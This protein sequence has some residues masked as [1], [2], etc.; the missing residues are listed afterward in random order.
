M[1]IKGWDYTV[2]PCRTGFAPVFYIVPDDDWVYYTNINGPLH[3]PVRID[4]TGL[5][6]GFHWIRVDEQPQTTWRMGF[7]PGDF[8]GFPETMGTCTIQP[9]IVDDIFPRPPLWC[10]TNGCC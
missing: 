9:P 4:G 2:A 3:V 5:Y 6:D 1:E 10:T 8:I 7:L